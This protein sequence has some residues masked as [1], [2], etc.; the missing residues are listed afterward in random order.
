MLITGLTEKQLFSS[1]SQR[2]TFQS[3]VCL[4]RR[5]LRAPV[6]HFLIPSLSLDRQAAARKKTKKQTLPEKLMGSDSVET[7]AV[8]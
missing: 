4:H 7:Q 1:S 6:K 3:N 8:S 5:I 2:V